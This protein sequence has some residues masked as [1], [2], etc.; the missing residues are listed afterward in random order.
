MENFFKISGKNKNKL[1]A[2]YPKN[3]ENIKNS[4]PRIQFYWFL[5][6]RECDRNIK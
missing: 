5:Q 4:K 3:H 2:I 1:R 6:K